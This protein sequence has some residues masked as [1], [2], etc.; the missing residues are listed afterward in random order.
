ML[1]A[2][3]T[4]R[5]DTKKGRTNEAKAARA[6]SSASGTR[7]D[8]ASGRDRAAGRSSAASRGRGGRAAGEHSALGEK[9][10]GGVPA[11]IMGPRIMFI[12]CLVAL[13]AFGLLMVYS[14]SSVEA[15]SEGHSST[16]YLESQAKNL[17]VGLG[18]AAFSALVPMRLTR[19]PLMWGVWGVFSLL[20]IAV[21]LVGQES[22]GA[23]RWII[24][25][26][27]QFQPSELAKSVII[28]TSA[29]IMHEFYDERS[30]SDGSFIA[31]MV[32]AVGVPLFFIIFEP[33]LG[34]CIIIAAT[35]FFM[36]ILAGI[37]GRLVA[38]LMIGIAIVGIVAVAVAPYRL[39]RIMA[40]LDPW[41]DPYGTGYQATLAIMAFA[42]GGL[43]GRG[44]GNSTMKYNYLPEA[45]NDYILAIIGEEL[46]FVG[47]LVFFAVVVGL[48]YAGF[49]IAAQSPTMQGK[50]I[51]YGCT[52][53][54]GVQFL[55]NI[56]GI[57]GVTPMTGKPLP[58]ISYGGSALIGA[59]ILAGLVLR[60]SL[61][62]NPHT[63]Y[64]AR[65]EGMR[66]VS[67]ADAAFM[68]TP[69][70]S[71]LDDYAT[72]RVEGSTAGVARPRS[73]RRREGFTVVDGTSIVSAPE[74][75]GGGEDRGGRGR[76]SRR[77]RPSRGG[78]AQGI[79]RHGSYER[80]NLGSDPA[81][82]LRSRSVRTRYD[83]GESTRGSGSRRGRG[84]SHD[85]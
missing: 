79:E 61:E 44:I 72:A 22:G 16:F 42:S 24:I 62:S 74:P 60:V 8:G 80:V 67:A 78:Y 9:L 73:A 32:V 76:G 85:R 47:T 5:E 41:A 56:M 17:L 18:F 36:A 71:S 69:G 59:L 48:I 3:P 14:A 33:D 84:D 45:H 37:S 77:E 39:E 7:G 52:T 40:L 4:K 23:T 46:G 12:A 64:D 25:A 66:V 65:R 28:L 19:S 11:R 43:F 27:F 75:R 21:L 13:V 58:F 51:G 55:V 31:R 15:L 68:E 1:M 38:G 35:V 63:V 83:E 29:M 26:G 54:I 57:L 49:K 81:D 70:V 82:R 10:I 50:M 20:L 2:T 53:M 6:K 30:I 34:T